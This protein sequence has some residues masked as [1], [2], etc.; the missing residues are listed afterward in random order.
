MVFATDLT[1]PRSV[2]AILDIGDRG[3]SS[4]RSSILGAGILTGVDAYLTWQ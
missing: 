4:G 1:E 3:S 2:Q